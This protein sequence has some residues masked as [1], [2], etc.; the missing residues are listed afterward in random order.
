MTIQKIIKRI[1]S[2]VGKGRQ[3]TGANP[4]SRLEEDKLKDYLFVETVATAN[5]VQWEKKDEIEWRKFPIFSQ[6]GSGSCVAQTMAKLLGILYWLKNQA[7]VHF[8]ATHIYKRRANRPAFGMA[9]IDAFNIARQGVTLEELVPSQGMTDHEMDWTEIQQY[10]K[11]VGEVFRIGNF[12]TLPT[13]DIETVASVIQT[14]GKAVMVWFYWKADEWTKTPEIKHPGLDFLSA[15]KHSVTA[16]DFFL[17]DGKK[18]LLIEDSWGGRYGYS[19]R[20][21]ITEDFYKERN[22]FAA[23]P[24]N[25]RFDEGGDKP[26]YRFENVLTFG[27]RGPDTVALQDIL[28]YEGLFPGNI[29]STGYYGAITAKAVMA[30]QIKYNVAPAAEIESLQ[31]RSAGPKTI[32]KLNELYN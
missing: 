3:G 14:T 12:L 1:L 25:F 4:D 5:P 31:G 32:A 6:D 28:R 26:K 19:G 23:Y 13:K 11:D 17:K 30:F 18:C 10:K 29:E 7:Y 24:M 2:V 21:I 20:R 9:G 22:F 15:S 27:G 16:T 8:S